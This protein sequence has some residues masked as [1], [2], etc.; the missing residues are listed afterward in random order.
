MNLPPKCAMKDAWE[1]FVK[2]DPFDY[3]LVRPEVLSSWERC[4]GKVDPYKEKNLCVLP[5]EDFERIKTKNSELI[6]IAILV[7]E[8]LYNFVRGSGFA[9]ALLL[10]ESGRLIDTKLIGDPEA[11]R[12]HKKVN[13]VPGS[14]W[15]ESVMGTFAPTLAFHHDRPFQV[16][17][18]ENWCA[19]LHDGTTSAAPIHDPDTRQ[20][21]GLLSMTGTFEKVHQH[22]LGMVIAAVDSIEKQISARRMARASE[23]A[24]QYKNLI[25]ECFADGLITLDEF[26]RITHA[27]QKAINIFGFKE[28][29]VGKNIIALVRSPYGASKKNFDLVN[30]INSKEAVIDHFIDIYNSSEIIR[31]VVNM[32]FLYSDGKRIGKLL[33]IQKISRTAR[34]VANTLGNYARFTFDD[35]IGKDE[36]FLKCLET[37]LKVS[38]NDSNVLLLGESGT[39][40]DL[41]AQAIHNA[42]SRSG[43]TYIAINCAAIPRDLLGSELFG[44]VEGAFTGAKKGGNPGKFELADG[45]TIFLD[46]IGEMPL[47]MQSVLLRVIEEKAVTRIG[48]DKAI[49]VDVRIIAATNKD[50]AQEVKKGNFRSDLYYRINVVSIEIPPLRERKGDI[51]LLVTH[52]VKK[53]SSRMGKKIDYISPDVFEKCS[54]YDWPGNVRELQNVIERAVNLSERNI[55]SPDIPLDKISTPDTFTSTGSGDNA[56]KLK[57][58][59]RALEHNAILNCLEKNR[60]NMMLAAKE[61]G[62]ARSTLYRKMREIKR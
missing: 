47:D 36:K 32:R 2:N 44:Y 1:K 58:T 35:L 29:P 57:K 53:L 26:G 55:L 34:L 49:S 39:G 54:L 40:K 38:K 3:S 48:G 45:G 10:V 13:G 8:N 19:C 37:G 33:I 56:R 9:I 46:E 23:I 60:G 12:L 61:L 51:P 43:Q 4:R 17:P 28:N 30:V 27:N 41:F 62:I 11:T 16:Q 20:I 25:M 14:D 42:S 24:H 5:S 59:M 22:T 7:M 18:Y 21:I 52:F 50:L 31:C 15:S 6:D